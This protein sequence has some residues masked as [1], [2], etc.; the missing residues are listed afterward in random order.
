MVYTEVEAQ[1]KTE[2][3]A[4]CE[5][6]ESKIPNA[7]SC[8]VNPVEM[9]FLCVKCFSDVPSVA[10]AEELCRKIIKH[11]AF[12][13]KRKDEFVSFS[14]LGAKSVDVTHQTSP[15]SPD[16]MELAGTIETVSLEEA[17]TV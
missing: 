12:W 4:V 7:K 11:Q 5:M 3:L 17:L 10:D 15:T 8:Y 16:A 2:L 13:S 9:K 6:C 1:K 14:T